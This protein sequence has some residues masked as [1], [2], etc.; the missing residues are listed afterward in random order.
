[1]VQ[2]AVFLL[3]AALFFIIVMVID[4]HR[5][6]VRRYIVRSRSVRS[7]IRIVFIADLHENGYGDGNDK[8]A[9]E[10]AAQDPDLILVGG[11]LIVSGRVFDLYKKDPQRAE[12]TRAGD[13]CP[14]WM[15]NSYALMQKLTRICPVI[16]VRGNH[17][18]RLDYYEELREYSALF[19]EKMEEAGVKFIE[20]GHTDPAPGIRL[21]GLEL[22]MDYYGKFKKTVLTVGEIEDLIGRPDPSYY[23]ILL[24]HTPVHFEQYAEWGADLCL[25]G[26][27][28]GGLM[29]LPVIGGVV[30]TRPSLF[31]KY[32]GGQ[33]FYTPE[34]GG[35]I[36]STLILTCGLG[37]HTLPIRIFNPGEISVVEI[38]PLEE[39]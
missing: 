4:N 35:G 10:I 30:G 18:I 36:K 39:S 21:Q 14:E 12:S 31:P 32:S 33:Y 13:G 25:C 38:G 2:I 16:F 28:H 29:R 15:K 27:V 22:P 26:H 23:N 1:M 20:N 19:R 7:K 6:V 34:A 5:F 9:R 17:E 3:A 8:L 11:D 24:T 37:M